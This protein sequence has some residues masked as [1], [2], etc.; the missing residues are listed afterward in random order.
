MGTQAA[1]VV[2]WGGWEQPADRL[3]AHAGADRPVQSRE[4]Q[5][6]QLEA[7]PC[8]AGPGGG[9]P[10]PSGELVEGVSGFASR[11]SWSQR[12]DPP[13]WLCASRHLSLMATMTGHTSLLCPWATELCLGGRARSWLGSNHPPPRPP[14]LG[15]HSTCAGARPR[16]TMGAWST[17]QRA[18]RSWPGRHM[19]VSALRRFSWPEQ[20][21]GRE[22]EGESWV[23]SAQP[24]QAAVAS[25]AV[26]PGGDLPAPGPR[27]RRAACFCSKVC[28]PSPALPPWLTKTCYWKRRALEVAGNTSINRGHVTEVN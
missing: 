7:G 8:S 16:V 4:A 15:L 5:Q 3:R 23:T 13:R 2:S 11:G 6:L 18:Q 12:E 21:H 14:L 26:R 22:Q 19:E 1:S 9:S 24:L 27:G 17:L 10:E 20:H 28:A 25:R